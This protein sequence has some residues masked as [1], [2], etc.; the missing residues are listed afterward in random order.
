[1]V[2]FYLPGIGHALCYLHLKDI[3]KIYLL[4]SMV[5][6]I[7][8]SILVSFSILASSFCLF[9]SHPHYP[10][11]GSHFYWLTGSNK[12]PPKLVLQV[13]LNW[14]YVW[15]ELHSCICTPGWPQTQKSACLWLPNTGIKDMHHHCP[16][17]VKVF[18]AA[19]KKLG[20]NLV[21]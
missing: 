9:Y 4:T 15:G 13:F 14:L 5:F 20:L 10:V 19:T 8:S 17:N 11:C 3:E 6:T 1:V 2:I 18:I 12:I 21:F 7:S 16:V